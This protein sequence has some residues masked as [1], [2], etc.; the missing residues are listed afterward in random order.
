MADTYT[1]DYILPTTW[2]NL[3]TVYS[4]MTNTSSWVQNRSNHNILVAYSSS[5]SA[6]TGGGLLIRTNDI[7]YGTAT[8]VWAKALG[9]PA[10]LAM[11]ITD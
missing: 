3:T 1:T 8:Y 4:S 6:P 5:G 11:G 9:Q 7:T 2:T 10:N